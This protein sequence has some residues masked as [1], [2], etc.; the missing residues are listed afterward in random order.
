VGSIVFDAFDGGA[1]RAALD[2]AKAA[3]ANSQEQ[4]NELTRQ[5]HAQVEDAAIG[6]NDAKDRIRAAQS[7]Y[8][9]S[10]KNLDVQIEKYGQGLAITLDMLNAEAQLISAQ[11]SL[12]QAR[13]DYY[14]AVAQLE[15]ALGK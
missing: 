7:S 10:R 1:N 5:I 12:V 14:I 15:Y 3:Q 6:V 2:E 8:D 4:V 11:S 13:Y 9:A